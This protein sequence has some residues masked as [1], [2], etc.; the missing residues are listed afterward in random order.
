MGGN[1][2]E[3]QVHDGVGTFTL[4]NLGD[5]FLD[6]VAREIDVEVSGLAASALGRL[7]IQADDAADAR[8]IF[9]QTHK[10]GAERT[11]ATG[12]GHRTTGEQGGIAVATRRGEAAISLVRARRTRA[13]GR[14]RVD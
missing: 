11:C 14:G 13:R 1:V 8:S 10:V 3:G 6:V 2:V 9:E 4:Q 12:Y 5:A 7:A